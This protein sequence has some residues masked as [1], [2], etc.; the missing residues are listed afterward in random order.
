VHSGKL[1][2]FLFALR[3]GTRYREAYCNAVLAKALEG[4]QERSDISDHLGSI[5]F[6]ALDANPKL[7][8]ELGTRG[9][10]STR[11]LLAA[12]SLTGAVL[13]SVDIEDCGK[14][15][16]PFSRQ[17]SFVVA[18]DVEF[19]QHGFVEWCDARGI[20]PTIDVLFVDTSHEYEHTRNELAVW[21]RH[22]SPRGTMMF[23]DTNMGAGMYS[24]LDGS[25]GIGWSNQ[26]SVMQAIE[27]LV[28][29]KYP[30]TSFFS[31]LSGGYLVKHH[32]NCNG[33]TVL[34]KHTPTLPG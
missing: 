23:H 24:R 9:G 26:R 18:D 15:N 1:R 32:P 28:G 17:W 3:G 14:L 7:M 29:R 13:L 31:D 21:S 30:E 33:L 27:D 22:L 25:V 2:R 8:V 20:A 19:G 34:K 12:A 6:F 5:F 4:F 16:L 10:E 11:A